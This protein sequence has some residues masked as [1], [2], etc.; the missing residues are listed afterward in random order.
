MEYLKTYKNKKILVTGHTGFK[1]SWFTIWLKMLGADVI[2]YSLEP[3]YEKSIF[4]LTGISKNIKNH[5]GDIRDL[6]NLLEVFNKEKP[7]IVFH[8]AAQALV[9]DSYENPAYTFETNTQGTVNVLEAIRQTDSVH[10]AVFITTDKCYENREQKRG[11]QEDDPM[12]G[13]DPYSASKGAAELVIQ[14]YRKSFFKDKI[15]LASVRAG[16]VIGGGDWAKNRLI[17]DIIKAI[18]N[19]KE[20]EIRNPKAIR[21]WQFVLEPLGGYL[22]LGAKLMQSPNEFSEAWNFGPLPNE[23]FNVQY[24]VSRILNYFDHGKWIDKSNNDDPHEAGVLLLD[25]E[26]AMNKLHWKPVLNIEDSIQM[27]V[28]WYKNYKEQDVLDLCQTQINDYMQLWK[29]K[30]EG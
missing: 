7:E 12:G 9:L 2:G 17:P 4:E 20:I 5:I 27:T 3:P 19:N 11:Y 30:S 18:E 21:P 22:Q 28:E 14:A 13:F 1:G 6:N 8:F 24:V 15:G 16:N 23:I 25:I 29:S 26:K 10:T